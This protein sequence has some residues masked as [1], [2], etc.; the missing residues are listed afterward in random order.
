MQETK[1][2]LRRK[3]IGCVFIGLSLFFI[4]GIVAAVANM[5]LNFSF[6]TVL[7]SLAILLVCGGLGYFLDRKSTRLNSSHT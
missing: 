7:G 4:F 1:F 5:I 2:A 3:K 6:S